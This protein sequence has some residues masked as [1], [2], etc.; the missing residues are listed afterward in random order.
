MACSLYSKKEENNF[1][2]MN[3]RIFLNPI[4]RVKKGLF[5]NVAGGNLPIL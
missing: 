2:F 5:D 4:L 1:L 3:L